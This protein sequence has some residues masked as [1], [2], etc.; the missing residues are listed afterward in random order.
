MT[1]IHCAILDDYQACALGFADWGSL[2]GVQVRDFTDAIVT[3]DA[4]VEQ[5]AGFEIIV[6]M[7]ERTRFDAALLARLPRLKLLVSTGMRNSAIDMQTAAARGITVCGTRSLSYPAPELTWGLLLALARNIPADVASVRA[8]EKWQTRIGIG[9]SGKTLGIIGLGSIGSRIARYGQAFDMPVLAWSRS[10]TDERCQAVGAE[11]AASLD[12]LLRRADIVTLHV[13][14]SDSSRGLIGARELGLLKPTALLVN[15]SRGPLIDE[16][17][18]LQALAQNRIAGAAL[19]VYET[20][21]LPAEHPLRRL[22]NVVTTPHIGHVTR[23]QYRIF[24]TDAVDDIR[25]WL[26]QSPVRIL[27]AKK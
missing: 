11:R 10:L 6:A 2:A 7:R 13:V 15:T 3:C 19:D 18:L 21:P 14:L 1:L 23:E 17:A 20:E 26:K 5:L 12:A 22:R 16:P 25:A 9:L 24:Y 8:G 27:P 4:L